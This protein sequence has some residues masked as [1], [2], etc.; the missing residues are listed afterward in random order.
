MY[1]NIEART[2]EPL[3]R[4]EA[5]AGKLAFGLA[6]VHGSRRP[7][8]H[9]SSGRRVLDV[10]LQVRSMS[11]RAKVVCAAAASPGEVVGCSSQRGTRPGITTCDVAE[12]VGDVLLPPNDVARCS[13]MSPVVWRITRRVTESHLTC[14]G[15][16]ARLSKRELVR[17]MPRAQGY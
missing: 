5:E 9:Y 17:D 13:E 4:L 7:R 1:L 3:F 11:L 8:S 12:A 14:H 2:C 10:E 6:E 15:L 16:P